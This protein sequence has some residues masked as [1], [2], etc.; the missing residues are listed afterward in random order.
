[1]LTITKAIGE[2]ARFNKFEVT[3]NGISA[4]ALAVRVSAMPFN[5]FWPGH[6]RPLDQTEMAAYVSYAADEPIEVRVK[7][8]RSFSSAVVR[9]LS[10]GVHP[11]V[12]D[13]EI[14]FTLEQA[15]QYTLE[16]DGPH[17][18]LHI[19]ADP[20]VTYDAPDDGKILRFDAG[21]HWVGQVELTDRTTV[22][23]HRDAVVHGSF[24]AVGAKDIRIL[25]EG[26]IDGGWDERETDQFLLVYDYS[27]CP[28]SS[29]EREQMAARFN[30]G[31][32][33]PPKGEVGTGSVLYRDRKHFGR[34]IEAMKPVRSGLHFYACK[35]VTVRGII[36]RDSAGLSVTSAGCEQVRFD[37]VK[38]IGMYR[39]NSDGIDFYNCRHCRIQNSFLRTFDDTIGIKGQIGWDTENTTDIT[40]ENTVVWN[41]W[42][43]SLE[44]GA[45]S[46]ASEI[47]NIT[48]RNCDVIHHA[49][50][51]MDIKNMDR[52]HVHD[53][54]F[55]DIRVEYSHHD[56]KSVYQ[57]HDG[58]RYEREHNVSPLICI[59]VLESTWSD[60]RLLGKNS[61]IIFRNIQILSE[62]GIALP[63]IRISGYDAEH[64]T[65][66]VLLE[67]ISH[68]GRRLTGK[69]MNL[70]IEN[71]AEQITVR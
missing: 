26:V 30:G 60:D 62:D 40:V 21:E 68:N 47:A 17:N 64:T 37:R 20:I 4:D 46:V 36:L 63:E 2:N 51:V 24:F 70:R 45:D 58:M 54:L 34:L 41:D 67:N 48:F 14:V 33:F 49:S 35:D 15:G 19:F 6:Q 44:F 7:P 22:L 39:Y 53:V 23:I 27:R 61:D 10:K 11:I 5:R 65:S 52:A 16:L 25:G 66:C 1:M 12:R 29:W 42:G 9:P 50:A 38:L 71:F 8:R 31:D 43:H 57:K 59:Q 69:E 13:G 3:L 32:L 56:L 55:E 28:A 18:A